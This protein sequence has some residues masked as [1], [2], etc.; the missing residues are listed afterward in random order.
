MKVSTRS[1]ITQNV[2]IVV[3]LKLVLNAYCSKE[4]TLYKPESLLTPNMLFPL[5]IEK[6]G[7]SLVLPCS[8]S[9]EMEQSL[10]AFEDAFA[11]PSNVVKYE[12]LKKC[13]QVRSN[14]NVTTIVT[15]DEGHQEHLLSSTSMDFQ[16]EIQWIRA[17]IE[18]DSNRE[19][20]RYNN[21]KKSPLHF[22]LVYLTGEATTFQRDWIY[23][24]LNNS[25]QDTV[26]FNYTVKELN[27][28]N[29]MRKQFQYLPANRNVTLVV[30]YEASQCESG[31]V[32]LLKYFSLLFDL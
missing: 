1:K 10:Q 20:K 17:L 21:E 3:L 18:A 4:Q 19:L 28:E 6:R 25:A 23:L 14:N 24:I 12:A 27:M 2:F 8:N 26:Q 11:L 32:D 22:E 15:T 31:N 30:V 29:N 7:Y 5:N 16:A 13:D 9:S